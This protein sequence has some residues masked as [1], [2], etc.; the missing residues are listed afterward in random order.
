MGGGEKGALF[1]ADVDEGRLEAGQ[2]RLDLADIDVANRTMGVGTIDQEL[3]KAVVLE[4][5]HAGLPRV[6]RDQYFA[7]QSS[8]PRAPAG[9]TRPPGACG[10][11]SNSPNHRASA[12]AAAPARGSNEWE[13]G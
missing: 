5:G 1:G 3:N 10:F 4:N 6:S 2:D 12:A 11:S 8:Y 13:R 7:L 9:S